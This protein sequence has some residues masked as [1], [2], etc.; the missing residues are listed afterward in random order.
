MLGE[1]SVN[2]QST[3]Q[4]YPKDLESITPDE[5]IEYWHKLRLYTWKRFSWMNKRLG[6]DLDEIA[7]QAISDTLDGKRKWPPIDRTTGKIKLDVPFFSFLCQVVNSI[8]SHRWERE[9]RRVPIEGFEQTQNPE[10]IHTGSDQTLTTTVQDGRK[11]S[12]RGDTESYVRYNLIT[13]KMCELASEDIE[14]FSIICLWREDPC[15]KPREI[16]AT[17]GL[18]MAQMR[19][20]QKRLSRLLGIFR[21]KRVGAKQ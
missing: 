6:E 15:L 3:K 19:A 2:K 7:H 14:A 9:I 10:D 8:A 5:W 4:S 13:G 20:A 21:T 18:T 1:N 11:V 17:L 16:A 12:G